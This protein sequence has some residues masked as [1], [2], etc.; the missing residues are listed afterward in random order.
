MLRSFPT[1]RIFFP[2]VIALVLALSICRLAITAATAGATLPS[3]A[4]ADNFTSGSHPIAVAVG[5][6]NADLNADIAVVN[7]GAANVSVRLG[8][9]DGSFGPVANFSVGTN[10]VAIAVGDLNGD[11]KADLVIANSGSVGDQGSVSILLG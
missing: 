6:F 1:N 4:P 7:Q 9:G 3:F 11:G 5:N 2:I 10:P 8:D